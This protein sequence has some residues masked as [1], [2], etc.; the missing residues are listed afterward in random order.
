M[1]KK[2]MTNTQYFLI[3]GIL[4][5]LFFLAIYGGYVLDVTNENWLLTGKD[6]T[7]HYIG[8]KYY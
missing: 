5:A 6:L 1:K 3:G 4:G 7:Q 2:T 8:W